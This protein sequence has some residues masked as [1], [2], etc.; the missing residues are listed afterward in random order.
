MAV[1][2]RRD[3]M[4]RRDFLMTASMAA[5]ASALG[6][7]IKRKEPLRVAVVG[8]G[9]Q[10]MDVLS[11]LFYYGASGLMYMPD[12]SKQ[13]IIETYTNNIGYQKSDNE[14]W[15]QKVKTVYNMNKQFLGLEP[16]TRESAPNYIIMTFGAG[17]A[18]YLSL[19]D[20]RNVYRVLLSL[21][22]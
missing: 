9:H 11:H 1:A 22:Y 2:Q 6:E 19:C 3:E 15:W 10:G 4:K 8:L 18:R 17:K 13:S 21:P 7:D 20:S 16:K 14:Q 12:Y 5:L